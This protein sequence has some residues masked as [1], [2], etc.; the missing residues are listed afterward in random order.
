VLGALTDRERG[1]AY[2]LDEDRTESFTSEPGTRYGAVRLQQDLRDSQTRVGGIFTLAD[3]DLP[4]D[5]LLD[6]LPSSAYSGGVDFEH[7]WADREWSLWGFLAG[8]HVRGSEEAMLQIQQAPNHYHQRPDQD[9]LDLDPDRTW[10]SGAE[11]RMQLEKQGGRHWTG[12]VWAAQRTPGFEVNDFGFSTASERLDGGARISYREPTPGDLLRSYRFSLFTFHNWRHSVRDDFF[13][14]SAWGE[15]HKSANVSFSS[16]FTLLNWWGIGVDV[17]Y[18]PEVLSDG[19]TRGGPLMVDPASHSFGLSANTDRRDAV[20]VSA[21]ID[22][23]DG[24]RGGS[25]TSAR[26]GLDIR[27]SGNLA[28]GLSPSYSRGT[29]PRQY[30]ARFEDPSFDPTF[31][32]RYLFGDLRREEFS[33]E[34]RLDIILSPSLSIEVFAQPL[35][36][37][38]EF[39]GYKQLAQPSSFDFLAF[40]EGAA[41]PGAGNVSCEGGEPGALA[42]CR[43]DGRIFFDYSGNG[44]ADGSISEQNFNVRSLRGNAV[45]RWEFRPGSRLFLVWQQQRQHRDVLGTFDFSRDAGALF[46]APGEHMFMIKVDYWLNL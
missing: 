38:G 44:I 3:R 45:L 10:L 31:G 11:W 7:T 17:G 39:T 16:N 35:V 9:Y 22:Y 18:R 36:S 4:G 37:A 8:S 2:F 5:G 19:L 40:E 6:F 28:I 1:W 27:P 46:D 15:A 30:V 26:L 13:S 33:M 41:V 25:E 14:T 34:T 21:S 12:A 23:E 43:N 32:A 20:T 24:H 42:L 29:D